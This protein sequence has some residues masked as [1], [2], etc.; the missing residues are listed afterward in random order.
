MAST[1]LL[2][3]SNT[4]GN[5]A[6]IGAL[7]EVTL[8]TQARKLRIHDGVQAGG[9]VVAN[10]AD[11]NALSTRIDNLAIADISGLQA[12]LD[13]INGRLDTAELDIDNIEASYIKKDGT[14]A[15]TGAVDAGL[16][17]V[18]NVADPTVAGD[19]ANKGYVDTQISGLGDAFSYEGTVNGGA[20]SGTATNI[21]TLG[22]QTDT[23]SYYKVTASGYVT[24]GTTVKYV[25]LGDGVIFNSTGGYDVIDNTNA[26]IQGTLNYIDVTGGADT[27]YV[28]D[29]AQDVKNRI[30]ALEGRDTGVASVSGTAPITVNNTDSANPVVGISNATTTAD[31]AMSSGD[32]TKLNGIE[33]GAQVNTVT[34]VNT[35]TGAVTV[36]KADVG[37]GSVSNYGMA[38]ATQATAGTSTTLYVSPQRVR[39]FVEG[40]DYTVD[41][42]TF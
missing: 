15:F 19:A 36:T 39:D 32:K 25:N 5:D 17:K 11:V 42:G 10:M 14:V 34:S 8:D 18:V 4:A 7:G 9:Y 27:G 22:G 26:E 29:L 33:S 21:T 24:D 35:K 30:V 31:G 41:G 16:N 6:Y 37:L 28:V 2:K 20:G 38:N 3:R 12:A 13:T 40:G 1:I 23:G